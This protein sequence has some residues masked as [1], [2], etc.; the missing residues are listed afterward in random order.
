MFN[1][2]FIECSMNQR[3]VDYGPSEKL[4]QLSDL[5]CNQWKLFLYG[6]EYVSSFLVLIQLIVRSDQGGSQ[7][8]FSKYA[9]KNSNVTFVFDDKEQSSAHK[10]QSHRKYNELSLVM[11]FSSM[12]IPFGKFHL[13]RYVCKNRKV[14]LI[15]KFLHFFHISNE[16]YQRYLALWLTLLVDM[17]M[18][19]WVGAYLFLSQ[20]SSI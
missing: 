1:P 19:E 12:L 9:N 18:S 8:F 13:W 15:L 14:Y 5:F 2:V 4:G 17:W 7:I 20:R 3:G 6:S 11:I 16:G 10:G